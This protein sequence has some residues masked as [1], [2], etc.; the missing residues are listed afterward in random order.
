MQRRTASGCHSST[1]APLPSFISSGL[2]IN[3]GWKCIPGAWS[4]HSRHTF[5]PCLQL[6]QHRL[7]AR[8][9]SP[10]SC[11]ASCAWHRWNTWKQQPWDLL[12]APF[13]AYSW[14]NHFSRPLEGAAGAGGAQAAAASLGIPASQ[15]KCCSS[16]HRFMDEFSF[17]WA[18]KDT[19]VEPQSRRRKEVTFNVCFTKVYFLRIWDDFRI[20]SGLE[21][22]HA[23]LWEQRD[24]NQK[25]NCA[26]SCPVRPGYPHTAKH[27]HR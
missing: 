18:I 6:Q 14:G 7:T 13:P 3:Q 24:V 10:G 5:I 1:S 12:Q 9:G 20:L 21:Q 23:V 27:K 17:P 22:F 11:W 25:Q 15:G 19:D 8:A 26:Q 4:L 2:Q 16:T